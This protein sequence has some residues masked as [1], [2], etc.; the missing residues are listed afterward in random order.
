M[1]NKDIPMPRL[2]NALAQMSYG[3]GHRL[4]GEPDINIFFGSTDQIRQF[5]TR[6]SKLAGER[7]ELILSNDF[8]HTM[9][10]ASNTALLEKV[11]S[12]P[13]TQVIYYGASFLAENLDEELAT[14]TQSCSRL[15]GYVPHTSTSKSKLLPAPKIDK[16]EPPVT[17][18]KIT[19]LLNKFPLAEILNQAVLANLMVANKAP[20]NDQYLLNIG[21]TEKG[22]YRLSNISFHSNVIVKSDLTKH[23]HMAKCAEITKNLFFATIKTK[24][25]APLVTVVFGDLSI[26]ETVI[27]KTDTRLFGDTLGQKSLVPVNPDIKDSGISQSEEQHDK[28]TK[29]F[30]HTDVIIKEVEECKKFILD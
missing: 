10:G 30:F 19:M 12:T 15:A 1:L 6:A 13:E 5:R 3:L 22:G 18:K 24:G 20:Y 29:T 7:P 17:P 25:E 28:K 16:Q 9:I 8:P 14:L 21:S 2:M 11:V 4:E 23:T 27:K 26:V